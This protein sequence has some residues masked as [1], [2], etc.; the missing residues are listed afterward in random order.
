MKSN[1]RLKN[2]LLLFGC[3]QP[4]DMYLTTLLSCTRKTKHLQFAPL[5]M[6]TQRHWGCLDPCK[7]CHLQLL[8]EQGR[9]SGLSEQPSLGHSFNKHRKSL[10][11][12]CCQDRTKKHKEEQEQKNRKRNMKLCHPIS[13]W[14]KEKSKHLVLM[15]V[16]HI[17]FIFCSVYLNTSTVLSHLNYT[18]A[19]TCLRIRGKPL[20]RI[21][22]ETQTS[23]NLLQRNKNWW[24]LLFVSQV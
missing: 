4:Q 9:S 1:R 13:L 5:A 21:T 17:L 18:D 10:N 20:I 24:N 3:P 14:T 22:E 23:R 19:M 11:C 16:F 6:V 12:I 15:L 7:V 8:G 2:F